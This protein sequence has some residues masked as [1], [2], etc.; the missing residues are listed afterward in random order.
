[1]PLNQ[2]I[3]LLAEVAV[4]KL[5]QERETKEA[6]P[7][8]MKTLYR[9]LAAAARSFWRRRKRFAYLRSLLRNSTAGS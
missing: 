7:D 4:R 6:T 2:L 5:S 8:A 9:A 1:M 3:S